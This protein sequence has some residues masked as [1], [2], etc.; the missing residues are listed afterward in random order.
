VIRINDY[1]LHNY[2][3]HNFFN[4]LVLAQFSVLLGNSRPS[5][6]AFT[7]PDTQRYRAG[8][9]LTAFESGLY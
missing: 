5:I 8:K 3:Y 7:A 4:D 2:H 6:S 9:I 1:Y